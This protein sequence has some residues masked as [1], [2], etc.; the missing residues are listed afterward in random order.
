MRFPRLLVAATL[1]AAALAVGSEVVPLVVTLLLS[2]GPT[3]GT[4]R[5]AYR[6]ALTDS[7]FLASLWTTV[8]LSTAAATLQVAGGFAVARALRGCGTAARGAALGVL[9]M[10]WFISD[11]ASVV[12]WRSIL[13]GEVGVVDRALTALG[14]GPL[15]PLASVGTARLSLVAVS[16][17]QGVG[18]ATVASLGAL[19]NVPQSLW[20]AAHACGLSPW[21]RLTRVELPLLAPTLGAVWVVAALHTAA[22]FALPARLTMGGPLHA[23]RTVSMEIYEHLLSGHEALAAAEGIIALVLVGLLVTLVRVGMTLRLPSKP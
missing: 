23:T 18:F 1:G 12:V 5:G 8:C 14:M 21:Q 15:R 3:A 2:L 20:R 22:Q 17:W 9:L 19:L 13:V 11:M 4:A 16:A 7:R 6:L 10:P